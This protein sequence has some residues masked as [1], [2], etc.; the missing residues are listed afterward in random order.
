MW[1]AGLEM[2]KQGDSK[3]AALIASYLDGKPIAREEHGEPGD[4]DLSMDQVRK[5]LGLKVVK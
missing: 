5:A 4:F 2:A 1:R 3:W